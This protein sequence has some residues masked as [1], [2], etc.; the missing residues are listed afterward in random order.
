MAPTPGQE[1]EPASSDQRPMIEEHFDAGR[2]PLDQITRRVLARFKGRG[3]AEL[4]GAIPSGRDAAVLPRATLGRRRSHRRTARRVRQDRCRRA[5][6]DSSRAGPDAGCTRRE[7]NEPTAVLRN[8]FAATRSRLFRRVWNHY[9]TPA[10][11]DPSPAE[12]VTPPWFV[13]AVTCAHRRVGAHRPVAS[14]RA[15]IAS[16]VAS[17]HPA[18]V[19]RRRQSRFHSGTP[20]VPTLPHCRGRRGSRMFLARRPPACRGMSREAPRRGGTSV[21]P[22]G[23]RRSAARHAGGRCMPAY[24]ASPRPRS[25]RRRAQPPEQRL[26]EHVRVDRLRDEV[27]HAGG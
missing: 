15:G 14:V 18:D 20:D 19:P 12:S 1:A 23:P 11:T 13:C 21:A 7:L 10:T 25:S 22:G 3:M 2:S 8:R 9:R 4:A 26:V 6:A 16:G 5:R 24:A 17:L 27:V